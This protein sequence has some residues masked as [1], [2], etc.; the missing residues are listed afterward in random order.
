VGLPTNVCDLGLGWGVC[1]VQT[2]S[3]IILFMLFGI[4]GYAFSLPYGII[5][6]FVKHANEKVMVAKREGS[7]VF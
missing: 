3:V 5:S 6:L 4:F 7:G 1:F 2:N